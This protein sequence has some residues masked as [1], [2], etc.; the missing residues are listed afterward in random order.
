MAEEKQWMIRGD[1]WIQVYY[2]YRDG[3]L[4]FVENDNKEQTC[5]ERE[6]DIAGFL[7]KYGSSSESPY[8]DIVGFLKSR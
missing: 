2:L 6:V 5:D 7:G 8:P 4:Y 1:Q 3:K